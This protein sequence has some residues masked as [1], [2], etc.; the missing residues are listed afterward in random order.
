MADDPPALLSAPPK[1]V[2]LLHHRGQSL[3]ARDLRDG[4]DP[5]DAVVIAAD[6]HQQVDGRD[7]LF[8]DGA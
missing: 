8:A 3:E 4:F 5:S 1:A 6:V 2:E 7:D